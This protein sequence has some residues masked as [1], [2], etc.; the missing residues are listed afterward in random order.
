M[1][2]GIT[3]VSAS[4]I[5]LILIILIGTVSIVS[6][7]SIQNA[8]K[9][10]FALE[11]S[12]IQEAVTKYNKDSIDSEYPTTGK[13]YTIDLTQVTTDSSGQF[14]SE[15]KDANNQ[16]SV[17]EIDLSSIGIT[18]TTYGNK[19]NEKDVYVV[20]NTGKVYYLA[21]IK[22]K[23]KTYYT[24]TQ[25]LINIKERNEK[26]K[27]TEASISLPTI[28]SDGIVQRTLPDG[29]EEKY[30][31]N[32]KA[33]GENI[34]TVK[35]ELGV[36]LEENAASYFKNN[37]Q[38]L[39]G[40]RIKLK[41]EV[42]ITIY[43]ENSKGQ[44]AIKY[45]GYPIIP[46]EFTASTIAT[47]DEVDEG[48][49]IYE[50]T[51]EVTE[52]NVIN[53]QTSRNQ[54]VWVPVP[55]MSEFVARDGWTNG[56]KQ[57]F[58]FSGE[59]LEPYTS[60][61]STEVEEYNKMRGSV[62]KYGGFYIGRYET[63]KGTADTLVV[64]KGA[65]IWNNTTHQE[66]MNYSNELYK[67]SDEV[68]STLIYGIQWDAALKFIESNGYDIK[69]SSSWGNYNDSVGNAATD[70][71]NIQT[72]GTNE[73]WKANN[74]YDIAGNVEEWTMEADF[75]EGIDDNVKRIIR[76]GNYGT[77][78]KFAPASFRYRQNGIGV[79]SAIYGFRVALYLK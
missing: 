38:T 6:Y 25:D 27:D 33:T 20:S 18:N 54:Y 29:S 8:K 51:G 46:E 39:H 78:G 63:G 66:A 28:S 69:N 53:A 70:S 14:Q 42:P 43:A 56:V 9:L 19:E 5:V 10:V 32:I 71:G 23:N 77:S 15:I 68:M 47:E 11:V 1:K 34:K 75:R 7:N 79:Y 21:G 61:Y 36:V 59:I 76:G 3:M 13:I 22:S 17:Y 26:N 65:N 48:V 31:A 60:G 37:G 41:E 67:D 57:T 45:A 64:K 12:E 30:I 74:I 50:G 16:I 24:L 72:S 2:K 58:V 73:T 49:V 35:Y 44:Y 40:D 4:I 55:D 52:A 62:E